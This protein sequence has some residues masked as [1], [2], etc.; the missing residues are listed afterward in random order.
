MTRRKLLWTALLI[1]VTCA[2][3]ALGVFIRPYLIAKYRGANADLRRAHLVRA[4]LAGSDLSEAVLSHAVLRGSDL[5][6][7]NLQDAMLFGTNLDQCDLRDAYL[8]GAT[9]R[10]ASMR[11][12][13]LQNAQL[14]GIPELGYNPTRIENVDLNGAKYDSRTIWPEGFDPEAAGAVLVE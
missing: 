2:V 6:G 5:R 7:A 13:S 1:A 8:G 4:R 11:G 3:V 12:A 14:R 9:I 10:N